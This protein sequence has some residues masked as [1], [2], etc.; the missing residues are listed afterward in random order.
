MSS[1]INRSWKV[2]GMGRGKDTAAKAEKHLRELGYTN[3]KII[4]VENDKASDDYLIELLKEND[5]DGVSI[6]MS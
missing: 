4:G 3:I 5:W 1:S 2:L 6:G